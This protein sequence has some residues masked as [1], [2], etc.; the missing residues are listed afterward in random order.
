MH[1]QLH[2]IGALTYERVGSKGTFYREWG[3]G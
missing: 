3:K 2:Y 1:A